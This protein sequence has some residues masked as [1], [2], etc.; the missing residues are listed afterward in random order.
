DQHGGQLLVRRLGEE[1]LVPLAA[2][3]ERRR[4]A[5]AVVD[6]EDELLGRRVVVDDDQFVGDT[7]RV[8]A[9]D[10]A[11]GVVAVDAAVEGQGEGGWIHASILP[12]PLPAVY[13]TLFL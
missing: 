10:D 13:A 8:E 5:E 6:K 3:D 2:E 4:A 7:E 9:A 11:L 12:G 1:Q